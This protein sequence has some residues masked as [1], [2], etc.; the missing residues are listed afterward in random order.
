MGASSHNT[1]MRI[2]LPVFVIILLIAWACLAWF[3]NTNTAIDVLL[4]LLA[5]IALIG[6]L[7]D[8]LS[9]KKKP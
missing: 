8:K 3:G 5:F 9:T 2:F 1:A 6:K 7:M 4:L